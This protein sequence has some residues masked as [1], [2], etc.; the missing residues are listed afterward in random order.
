MNIIPHDQIEGVTIS[1]GE[2]FLQAAELNQFVEQL[3]QRNLSVMVYTGYTLD[4]LKACNNKEIDSLLSKIDILID[5][6][7]D[8]N[9]KSSHPWIGSGNQNI[10]F[11]SNKYKHLED[12]FNVGCIY[13]EFFIQADGQITVTGF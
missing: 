5:G 11:L 12:Q 6:K 8:L 13:K 4:S 10:Y 9:I 7:Y 2:P 1:G 3:V